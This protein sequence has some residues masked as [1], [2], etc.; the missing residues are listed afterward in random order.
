MNDHIATI[1]AC[2]FLYLHSICKPADGGVQV[3]IHEAKT[4]G[5][6]STQVLENEPLA[7][8][9]AILAR[10]NAI[11]HTPECK[12]FTVTWPKYVSYCMENESFALPEPP[13]SASEGRL[14]VVYTASNYL[15]YVSKASFASAEYP[16]PFKHWAL[17][18]LDHIF[19]VVSTE[20]PVIH[21][22]SE[23]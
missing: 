20:E 16:G 7:E 12:V 3:V 10:S 6:V 4:G 13:T 11:V 14:F 22:A 19:N 8:V 18:C 1:R 5:P 23:A 17:L 21:V 15:E 2:E 9:K